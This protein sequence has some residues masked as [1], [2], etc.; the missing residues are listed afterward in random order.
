MA[1]QQG[2]QFAIPFYIKNGDSIVSPDLVDDVRIQ[3]GA[4]LKTY[5]NGELTY[6]A[7]NHVFGFPV[8][9]DET[10]AFLCATN[11]VQYQVGLKIGTDIVYSAV[12]KLMVK[13]SIIG[14][15]W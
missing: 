7:A 8:T 6:D 11:P 12:G 1:I 13:A 4:T 5:S 9:Q 14:E 2:D 3:I 10:R 15:D